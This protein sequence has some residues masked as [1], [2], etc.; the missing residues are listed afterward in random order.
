M[1]VRFFAI[2]R[3][4]IQ[5]I[6][7]NNAAFLPRFDWNLQFSWHA[8]PDYEKS[9]RKSEVD[10]I[11]S[12]TMA[13]GLFSIDREYFEYL[14][15]HLSIDRENFLYQSVSLLVGRLRLPTTMV[16]GLSSID[17]EYFYLNI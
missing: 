7:Q 9:R 11:R 15:Q 17:R 2:I 8:I 12:P 14:G 1:F 13:G 3:P 6:N 10:P 5:S 4:F 16:G